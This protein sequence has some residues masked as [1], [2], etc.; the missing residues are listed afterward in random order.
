ASRLRTGVVDATVVRVDGVGA[1]RHD[2]V[3]VARQGGRGTVV[4][5]EARDRLL[6][7]RPRPRLVNRLLAV[8]AV[9]DLV[10]AVQED[11]QRPRADRAL[12]CVHLA[13]DLGLLPEPRKVHGLVAEVVLRRLDLVLAE[14]ARIVLQ[15]RSARRLQ[16]VGVGRSGRLGAVLV[17]LLAEVAGPDKADIAGLQ[18]G[19]VG[20][21]Q[22]EAPAIRRLLADTQR[23]AVDRE[24]R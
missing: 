15:Q 23:Y 3:A 10:P 1:D 18:N 21:G 11:D 19:R 4:P 6:V 5:A 13:A 7:L 16:P 8:A 24:Q 14:R 22:G 20:G 12:G 9:A 2:L 17:V